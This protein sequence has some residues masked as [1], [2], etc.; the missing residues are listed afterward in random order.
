MW[1][2]SI[3]EDTELPHIINT[4][5]IIII[6]IKNVSLDFYNPAARGLAV[7]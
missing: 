1:D 4:I 5:I 2:F 7:T 3:A 6:M